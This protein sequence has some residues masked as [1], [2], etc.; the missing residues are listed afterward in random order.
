MIELLGVISAIL[1]ILTFG[2][3]IMKFVLRPY[4]N[5]RKDYG[6]MERT[7]EGHFKMW[8]AVDYSY[9]ADP[10]LDNKDFSRVNKFRKKL[11]KMDKER[12]AFILRNAVQLG[13]KGDWGYWLALIKDNDTI[14]QALIPTLDGTAGWRPMWRT[15]YIM[16]KLIGEQNNVF[17]ERVP[18]KIK[19]NECFKEVLD[20]I[21]TIGVKKYL[22]IVSNGDDERLSDKAKMVLQEIN[23][24]SD[25]I[26][27]Y[28]KNKQFK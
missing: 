14:I 3:G 20:V 25:Q 1:A 13:M 21:I 6:D 27:E 4:L 16:E 28:V 26:D 18:T 2:W 17:I 10:L 22:K 24:Y 5:R 23:Q 12:L 7:I 15:G 8:K 11:R 9:R 19:D